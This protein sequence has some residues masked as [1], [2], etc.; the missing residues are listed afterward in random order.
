MA[1]AWKK[2]RGRMGPMA[3]LIGRWKA[4]AE[5]PM[6]P[7]ACVRDYQKFGDLYVRLEAE[8]FF[9]SKEAETKSYRELCMFGPDTDGVLAFWSYTSD[10]KKSSGRLADA[11]D[12]PP[13]AVCFEA[14]MAAGLA[15]Q[16]F[17]S[18]GG[19]GMRWVVE[20]KTKKGWSRLAEHHYRPA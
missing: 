14:Q 20:A 6:G 2:G 16:L 9:K 3:P 4:T 8:W 12:G 17:W 18:D 19:D 10:G 5:T 11:K 1:T 13:N 15:R 7:V